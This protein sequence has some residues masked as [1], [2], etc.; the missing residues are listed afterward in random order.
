MTKKT[1]DIEL[2]AGDTLTL[3]V[4]ITNEAGAAVNLTG[5]TLRYAIAPSHNHTTKSVSKTTGSGVTHTDAANGVAQIALLPADTAGLKGVYVHE[6]EVEDSAGKK[7]TAFVG[8][9]TINPA[10]H[11]S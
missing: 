6:L 1:Q 2:W 7:S 9:V 5:A 3:G 11:R 10:L 8:R 4:T